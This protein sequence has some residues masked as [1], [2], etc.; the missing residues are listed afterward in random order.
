MLGTEG[1]R[2]VGQGGEIFLFLVLDLLTKV[3]FGFLLLSNRQAIS[4]A[5]SGGGG[6][7]VWPSR[8]S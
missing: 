5:S 6:R 1:F 7:S 2:A 3:G 8:V 4:E